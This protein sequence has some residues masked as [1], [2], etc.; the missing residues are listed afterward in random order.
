M[1]DTGG[2]CMFKHVFIN[3]NGIWD[4]TINN[5][6]ISATLKEPTP[7]YSEQQ[8]DELREAIKQLTPKQQKI[9][10]MH[11]DGLSTVEIARQLGV[12]QSTVFINMYGSYPDKSQPKKC[13]GGIIKRLRTLMVERTCVI[14]GRNYKGINR[15]EVCSRKCTEKNSRLKRKNKEKQ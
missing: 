10:H 7:G 4:A 14:C 2:L 1:D 13:K 3:D 15:V 9:L 5:S 6:T 8:L 12:A 11:L